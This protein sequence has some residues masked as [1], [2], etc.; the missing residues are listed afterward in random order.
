MSVGTADLLKALNVVWDASALDASFLALRDASVVDAEYP[1]LH[2][3]EAA[4]THPFPY[5]VMDEAD[6]VTTDR[7]S[8][9]VASINEIRDVS[10]RFN[11]QARAVD[12]DARTPKEI[13]AF[14]A[15]EIMKVFGGHPTAVPVPLVLDHG[16]FLIAQYQNDF[17]LRT[18]DNEYQWIVAYLFRLDVPVMA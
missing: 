15:E 8:G 3:Q 6:S 1:V 5:C 13:A 2:D 7:M 12:G 17:G 18:D 11:V 4:P 9:G 16:G 14:L 10:V